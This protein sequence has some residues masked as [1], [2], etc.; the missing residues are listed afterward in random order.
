MLYPRSSSKIL[1]FMPAL[2]GE[3]IAAGLTK[4]GHASVCISTIPEAFDA[5]RS[6][7]FGFAI[8]TRPDI[9]LLRNIR[10]LPVINFEVFFHSEISGDRRAPNSKRFDSKAFLE[11][12][13]FLARTIAAATQ[14]VAPDGENP[15]SAGQ[16]RRVSWWT[17]VANILRS[18]SRKDTTN[19]PF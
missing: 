11:R 9:D 17:V 5:L 2:A 14:C 10:A 16:R 13:D 8:S 6:G 15:A 1:I 12:V 3:V 19:V 4:H 7:E 18:N